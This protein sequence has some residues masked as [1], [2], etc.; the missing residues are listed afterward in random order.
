VNLLRTFAENIGTLTTCEKDTDICYLILCMVLQW[1]GESYQCIKYTIEEVSS[2]V[3]CLFYI[4]EELNFKLSK[5]RLPC[6]RFSLYLLSLSG[7]FFGR[8]H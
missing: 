8:L 5:C 1:I 4:C 3:E 2:F 6:V 7:E